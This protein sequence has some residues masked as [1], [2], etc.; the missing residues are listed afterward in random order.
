MPLNPL[1]ST[2]ASSISN[3]STEADHTFTQNKSRVFT[4]LSAILAVHHVLSVN[5]GSNNSHV[6]DQLPI[7]AV[8]LLTARTRIVK[9]V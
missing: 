5:I 4:N 9:Q 8:C 2:G 6:S 1:Q 3:M 7:D